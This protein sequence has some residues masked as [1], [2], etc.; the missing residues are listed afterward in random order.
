MKVNFYD[1]FNTYSGTRLGTTMNQ[2][3]LN[4][5][6]GTNNPGKIQE[7]M[8]LLSNL[9]LVLLTPSSISLDLLI[10]E[11]GGS[12]QENAALK[13][14][15]WSSKSG[16]ACLSDDSGLEVDALGGAPGLYSHRFTANPNASDVERR[17]H[18]LERLESL[19]QPWTARFQCAVAIAIPGQDLIQTTGDCAGE[20]IK[21]E[22]GMNG[23]GYDPIFLVQGTGKTMAELDDGEKNQIS[24]RAR[25]IRS[26]RTVLLER[27]NANW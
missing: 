6:L 12:Y 19:P 9:P 25:A 24:H 13:A 2:L 10:E 27:A 4:L 5:L 14:I 26:A 18:L 16:L 22:R 15:A 23:F 21:E 1:L 3:P 8:A 11:T 20:I 7:M 17:N